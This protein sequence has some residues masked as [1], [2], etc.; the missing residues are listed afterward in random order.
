M[1]PVGKSSSLAPPLFPRPSVSLAAPLVPCPSVSLA[2]P[3]AS[4]ASACL[5]QLPAG[6]LLLAILYTTE[7]SET[8]W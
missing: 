8:L 4:C 6:I 3:L 2:A 5:E 1:G 7:T